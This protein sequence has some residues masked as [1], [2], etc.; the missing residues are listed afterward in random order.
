MD[1]FLS[2]WLQALLQENHPNS[3]VS[4]LR[5]PQCQMTWMEFRRS[6]RLG[7]SQCYETFHRE[8]QPVISQIQGSIEHVGKA[9]IQDKGDLAQKRKL[10]DL[11][12]KMQKYVDQQ[13]FEKAAEVR[14]QIRELEAKGGDVS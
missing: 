13:D 8:L 12:N 5:C 14:D 3:Y 9:P 10:E 7:C 1:G 4:S 2:N 6:G 11:R